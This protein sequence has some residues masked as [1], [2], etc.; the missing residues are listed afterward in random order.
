[1]MSNS[2]H[3]PGVGQYN[4]NDRRIKWQGHFVSWKSNKGESPKKEANREKLPPVG[5]Y[6]PLPVSY[7]LFES[8]DAKAKSK[9]ERPNGFGKV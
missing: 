6:A 7:E 2:I 3:T 1:M 8:I 9:K 4:N 5:T